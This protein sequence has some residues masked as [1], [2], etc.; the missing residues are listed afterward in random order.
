MDLC[1]GARQYRGADGRTRAWRAPAL[2]ML[3]FRCSLAN[4][5][6]GRHLT[7]TPGVM[8]ELMAVWWSVG[9]SHTICITATWRQ[10]RS[11]SYRPRHRAGRRGSAVVVRH[12]V[13]RLVLTFQAVTANRLSARPTSS[14]VKRPRRIVVED[15][16]GQ[17]HRYPGLVSDG[18]QVQ[19]M[20]PRRQGWQ[21]R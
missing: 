12:F 1:C 8:G 11:F 4:G 14:G 16:S 6:A 7:H 15:Y 19:Q 13:S 5:A 10:V 9:S 18:H 3:A 20:R 2:P 21:S 17:R